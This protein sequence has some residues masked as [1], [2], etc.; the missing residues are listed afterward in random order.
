MKLWPFVATFSASCP[1]PSL[2]DPTFATQNIFFPSG[3]SDGGLDT[4]NEDVLVSGATESIG[5]DDGADETDEDP[6]PPGSE[7]GEELH[8]VVLG[9]SRSAAMV[10]A[11]DLG[12]E[13]DRQE[14]IIVIIQ[15]PQLQRCWLS[16][17]PHRL[18][19]LFARP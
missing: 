8:N 4:V 6:A 15:P 13:E 1:Q 17:L 16:Q 18:V 2:F 5:G 14:W 7:E 19:V 9:A 12:L 10:H 3:L 11:L